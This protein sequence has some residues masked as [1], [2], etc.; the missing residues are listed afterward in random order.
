MPSKA[1][2]RPGEVIRAVKRVPG[3]RAEVTGKINLKDA[4]ERC[5]TLISTL[6]DEYQVKWLDEQ[7]I[8]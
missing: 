1:L 3:A 6:D 2:L 5:N 4:F 8:A 7:D